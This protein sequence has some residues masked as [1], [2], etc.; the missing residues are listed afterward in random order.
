MGVDNKT[1]PVSFILS[2]IASAILGIALVGGGFVI[3]TSS[4]LIIA[5]V[6][7]IGSSSIVLTK[8]YIDRFLSRRYR[9]FDSQSMA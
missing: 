3:S 9:P 7:G 4:L 6:L 5:L 2:G 1:G 8:A